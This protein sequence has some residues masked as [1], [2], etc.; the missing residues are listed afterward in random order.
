MTG[1]GKVRPLCACVIERGINMPSIFQKID[2]IKPAYDMTYQAVMFLCKVLL[3]VDI[4]ITSMA[5]A[6]RYIPFIPDP[7]MERGS[8]PYLYVLYG[9]AFCRPCDQK[10]GTHPHDSI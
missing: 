3:V 10:R 8:G 9:G 6:G 5:V 1:T 2:R 7:G 4:L